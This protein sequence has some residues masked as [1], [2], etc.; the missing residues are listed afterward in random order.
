MPTG[1]HLWETAERAGGYY[2]MWVSVTAGK[3]QRDSS[4]LS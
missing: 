1:D 4:R 3:N 2:G